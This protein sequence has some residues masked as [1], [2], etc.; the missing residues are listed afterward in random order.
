MCHTIQPRTQRRLPPDRGRV[1]KQEQERRLKSILCLGVGTKHL[2]AGGQDSRAVAADDRLGGRGV[3]ARAGGSRR[4]ASDSASV[5]SVSRSVWTSRASG[6][7]V[8]SS[9]RERRAGK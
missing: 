9:L 1:A 3:A 8:T 2:A 6:S 7:L 4:A 5:S